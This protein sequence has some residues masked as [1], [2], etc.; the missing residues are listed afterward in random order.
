L[1]FLADGKT[2]EVCSRKLHQGLKYFA[3]TAIGSTARGSGNF[4]F[5]ISGSWRLKPLLSK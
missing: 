5:V 1:A 4:D 2:A 3:F